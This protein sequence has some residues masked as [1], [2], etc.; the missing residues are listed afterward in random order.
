MQILDGKQ[1]ALQIKESLKIDIENN[2]IKKGFRA[3]KLVVIM[4]G[5]N[6]AS[7]VYVSGKAKACAQVG[8]DSQIFYLEETTT[9]LELEKLIKNLNKDNSVDGILLQL[10]V[11]D[12]IDGQKMIELISPDKDVDGLTKANLGKLVA[13]DMTGLFGCTPSG[14]IELLKHNNID[15]KSKDVVIINRSLL[16]GKPLA[17]MFL[18]ENATPIMAHSKT[19]ALAEK[20]RN[21]DI[22]VVAVGKKN[23]LTEDMVSEKTIVVDVGINRDQTTNKIC[24]DVDFENVSKKVSWIT[25]VPGGAG[26]MTIA[27]LLKNTYKTA[28]NKIKRN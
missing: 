28:L 21:A 4:V 22:V 26:P 20:T 18:N 7:H 5:N 12:H 17:F 10:P 2:F 3:P 13:N 15:L 14:V 9:E 11:P 25:P 6:P 8:M 1:C 16:V 23:F 19:N 27:M 24:G